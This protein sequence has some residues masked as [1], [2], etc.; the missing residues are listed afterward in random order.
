M[1][2]RPLLVSLGLWLALSPVRAMG[3]QPA[4]ALTVVQSGPT[5]EIASL[6]E[7]NE[8][9]IVFSEPMVV[10]GR[11]PDPVSAPFVTIRP[12]IAGTFRWSGTTILIFTPDPSR[13]LPFATQYEISIDATA[14]AVSGRR[15]AAPHRFTFTTPT[16]KLLRLNW[17]RKNK[18]YDSP[19]ILAL[20]F[21]Q[22]VRT[23]DIVSHTS[24]R[25]E[26]HAFDEPELTAQARARLRTNDPQAIPRFQAKVA[27]ASAAATADSALRF[28]AAADWD[29]IR[30]PPS[31]DLAVIEVTDPTP[32]DSWVQVQL[33]AT[34]PATEGRSVPGQPQSHRVMAEPTFFVHGFGCR[35]ECAPDQ[36][37]PIRLRGN[38]DLAAIQ[39]FISLRDITRVSP[40]PIVNPLKTPGRQDWGYDGSAAFSLEDAGYDRQ[41]PDSRYV[42]RLDP[43]LSSDDG[44]TLGYTWLDIVENWHERAFT[45][46]GDGHGVWEAGGGPALPFYSRNFKD[47]TQWALPADT[48]SS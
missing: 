18:R 21:N 29:R 6:G 2:S 31:P 26:P 27:A 40:Q 25:F 4:A 32:P 5:G 37:N 9:R 34:V 15:L 47:V 41:R 14:A 28:T 16:V 42:V 43:G 1:T 24:L 20:R 7:S 45:S 30:F 33:D 11:I 13:K 39:K 12:A 48:R 17:Y 38:I 8:I 44:Q 35:T 22:P 23:A 19:M 10:L 46:F 3:P 36:W